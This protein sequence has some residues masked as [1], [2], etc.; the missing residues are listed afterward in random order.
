MDGEIRLQ[1]S[2]AKKKKSGEQGSNGPR[3]TKPSMHKIGDP[4]LGPATTMLLYL[5]PHILKNVEVV[6]PESAH[7]FELL[8]H[9]LMVL[10]LVDQNPLL[11]QLLHVLAALDQRLQQIRIRHHLE[12]RP[13]AGR[14]LV[15][16]QVR[17]R[18][19]RI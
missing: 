11:L 18:D 9:L 15:G 5:H 16:D 8:H 4:C 7:P 12:S 13:P 10:E 17:E 6:D 19:Y 2:E 14:H 1:K 3:S